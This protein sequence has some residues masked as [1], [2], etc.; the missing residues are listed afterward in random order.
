M[1]SH[2]SESDAL[3]PCAWQPIETAPKDRSEI[4]LH[5]EPCGSV[6]NGYWLSEA[7]AGNGA[8]IWPYVHKTPTHWM[9]LPPAPGTLAAPKAPA[10]PETLTDAEG[11]DRMRRALT[12]IANWTLPAT[13]KFWDEEKTRPTSYEAEYGS[14]GAR[15]YMRNLAALTLLAVPTQSAPPA[16]QQIGGVE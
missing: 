1:T 16:A 15:D 8:W 12:I 13:G 3:A 7:Y 6:A 11:Y 5:R 4:L 2:N 10:V 14:N 9:P